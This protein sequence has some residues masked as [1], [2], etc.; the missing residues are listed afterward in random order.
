MS[1]KVFS[2]DFKPRGRDGIVTEP[3]IELETNEAKEIFNFKFFTWQN[4]VFCCYY[5]NKTIQP[6]LKSNCNHFIKKS[7]KN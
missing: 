3:Q 5:T 4:L 2:Y 6:I 7:L 1:Y